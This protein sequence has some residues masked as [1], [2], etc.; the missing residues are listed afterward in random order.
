MFDRLVQPERSRPT[1][2]YVAVDRGS[3]PPQG[4]SRA[5]GSIYAPV[6]QQSRP[7]P[8]HP[9]P[10]QFEQPPGY[11]AQ[12]P[13]V[14][15]VQTQILPSGHTVYVNAPP[16]PYGY[17]T[18]QYHPHS[19]QHHI[20]HQTVPASIPP[21]GE[22]YISVV[23]IQSAGAPVQGV[24]PGGTF[25][26]WQ[27]DGQNG[28][29]TVTIVNAHGPGGVPVAVTRVGN[30]TAESPRQQQQQQPQ[31]QQQ[32][33]SSN[34]SG[35][36]KEKGGKSRRG[37]STPSRRGDTKHQANAICSPLLEEFKSKK[38]RD[39]TIFE[40]KGKKCDLPEVFMSAS[41]DRLQLL[42]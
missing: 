18:V 32:Q 21:H 35:R 1:P 7:Q 30:P 4:E 14:Q 39:W 17:A 23:P 24:G 33:Q 13:Q 19:Q 26:Y 42:I 28:P 6:P 41:H 15:H 29:Q 22:Q 37:G 27:P 3:R 5:Q 36:G 11:T 8:L 12:S 40:I 38:N 34:H 2:Q 20:V 10:T 31:Q 25:A 9:Q 16:P